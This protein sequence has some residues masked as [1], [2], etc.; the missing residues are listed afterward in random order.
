MENGHYRMAGNIS[1]N[2]VNFFCIRK[3]NLI[4][5]SSPQNT[6]N[7]PCGGSNH[8]IC[9]F[10]DADEIFQQLVVPVIK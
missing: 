5:T 10:T 2:H 4:D 9:S 6:G 8:G 1:F 7:N 3:R